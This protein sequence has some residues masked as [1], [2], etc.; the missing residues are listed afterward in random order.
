[1]KPLNLLT[2]LSPVTPRL[3]TAV[4]LLVA[5]VGSIVVVAVPVAAR[6][7][8]RVEA[9]ATLGIGAGAPPRQR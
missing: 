2:P 8:A 7:P 4:P 5:L 1:M 9:S 6:E 3:L